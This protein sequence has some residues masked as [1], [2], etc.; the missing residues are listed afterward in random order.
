MRHQSGKCDGF[1][2]G[3]TDPLELYGE[4]Q[5]ELNA[6]GFNLDA[7]RDNLKELIKQFGAQ[8]VWDERHRLFSVASSLR[9]FPRKQGE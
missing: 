5:N 9:N 6:S 3:W 7:E 1:P 4:F 8:W 2:E